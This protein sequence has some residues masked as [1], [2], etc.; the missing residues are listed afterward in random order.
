MKTSMDLK[1]KILVGVLIIGI[2]LI[3]GWWVWNTQIE[4]RCNS[5]SDCKFWNSCGCA[6]KQNLLC[7]LFELFK[8]EV[9]W[10]Y[11]PCRSCGCLNG[12]CTSW[13]I[14]FKEAQKTKNIELCYEIRDIDCKNYCLMAVENL[15]RTKERVTLSTDKTEYTK[16]ETIKIILRNN[17]DKS[18]WYLNG[19]EL[20][21][22]RNK[23]YKIYQFLAEKWV[24]VT[25]PADC[26][27]VEGAGLPIFK[28]LSPN[29]SVV[30]T[31]DSKIFDKVKGST[32]APPGKY[33]FLMF[34]K[35]DE[36]AEELKEVYSN[37]FT[38]SA[39]REEVTITTDKTEYEQ[40]EMVKIIIKNNLNNPIKYL[41][42]IA[43]GLQVFSN[44]GWKYVN[45]SCAWSKGSKLEPNTESIF[46]L[47]NL[48]KPGR[49]RIALHY[50]ELKVINTK[51][52][53]KMVCE[54]IP[55]EL[56]ELLLN[57]KW[58]KNDVE[59]CKM[60]QACFVCSCTMENVWSV[61][62]ASID[63]TH[64]SCA[65]SVYRIKYKNETIVCYSENYRTPYVIEPKVYLPKD[66]SIIYS[67]EFVIKE[68]VTCDWCG[69]VCVKYP[70]SK[71]DCEKAGGIFLKQCACPEVAPPENLICVEENGKCVQKSK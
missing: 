39:G 31:W 33:K 2:L 26:S 12:K 14:I 66:W 7:L 71:E 30:F 50:K 61:D 21:S 42:N 67:N 19:H 60:C 5:D 69:R 1:G 17:L 47:T 3:G 59:P 15:I 55:K 57:G 53:G 20:C 23:G 63:V 46:N 27:A 49:Y 32:E 62:G 8:P 10:E 18:I 37:E 54:D 48:D 9:A 44:E 65:G 34:Y 11:H 25:P 68:K 64:I 29:D 22:D 36:K 51:E 6:S 13:D 28:E 24:D 43:C 58:I 45:T 4:N 35:E 38:I 16:G 40:G 70:I 56:E 52:L 41:E